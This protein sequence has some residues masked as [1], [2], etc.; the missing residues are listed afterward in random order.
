MGMVKGWPRAHASQLPAADANFVKSLII[1]ESGNCAFGHAGIPLSCKNAAPQC[2]ISGFGAGRSSKRLLRVSIKHFQEKWEPVFRPENA[3]AKKHFREKWEPVFMPRMRCQK[4]I[5]AKS[6]NRFSMPR[7]RCQKSIF[8]KNGN[9][10]S[11]RNASRCREVQLAL[12]HR[13][14]HCPVIMP[15]SSA[16][17]AGGRRRPPGLADLPARPAPARPFSWR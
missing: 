13:R 11:C 8:A 10:F 12:T 7:M 5:F 2:R 15:A 1:V 3:L 17:R 16:V 9:R 14:A 6:G 4:S